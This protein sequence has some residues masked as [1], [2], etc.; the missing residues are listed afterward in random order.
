MC[1]KPIHFLSTLNDDDARFLRLAS[2]VAVQASRRDENRDVN[3]T[4][5]ATR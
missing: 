4:K 5:K 2:L 3:P 1:S